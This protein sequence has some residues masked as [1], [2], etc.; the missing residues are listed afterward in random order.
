MVWCTRKRVFSTASTMEPSY[1]QNSSC[2]VRLA[3]GGVIVEL[4]ESVHRAITGT[5]PEGAATG[6][7]LRGESARVEDSSIAKG[8]KPRNGVVTDSRQ[9]FLGIRR[10]CA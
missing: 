10:I 9:P 4:I 7:A 1:S 3:V 5:K 6:L 8:R 2:L